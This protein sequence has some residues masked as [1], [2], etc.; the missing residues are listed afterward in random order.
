MKNVE[1]EM[2]WGK[3]KEGS[4]EGQSLFCFHPGS[5]LEF[6]FSKVASTLDIK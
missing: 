1:Y 2:R 3:K 5:E 6:V 4:A